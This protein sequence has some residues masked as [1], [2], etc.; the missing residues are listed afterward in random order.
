MLPYD[1]HFVQFKPNHDF[2]HRA[3]DR[4]PNTLI[5]VYDMHGELIRFSREYGVDN[6]QWITPDEI[7]VTPWPNIVET[8]ADSNEKRM[9]F[10]DEFYKNY[11]EKTS[12][13]VVRLWDDI[14]LKNNKTGVGYNE[15]VKAKNEARKVALDMLCELDPGY[16]QHRANMIDW[17]LAKINEEIKR[18]RGWQKKKAEYNDFFDELRF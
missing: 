1:T 10:L 13:N 12:G 7:D 2:N 14:R 11:I 5:R 16:T 8:A 4:W 18:A 9:K 15:A 17:P 3:F 6:N